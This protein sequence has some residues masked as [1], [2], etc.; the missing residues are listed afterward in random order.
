MNELELKYHKYS[1]GYQRGPIYFMDKFEKLNREAQNLFIDMAIEK[2]L[3]KAL[4]NA[5]LPQDKW[6]WLYSKAPQ[7]IKQHFNWNGTPKNPYGV[8]T[9]I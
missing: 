7:H 9:A 5:R 4:N 2:E 1:N 3:T 8:N 6:S